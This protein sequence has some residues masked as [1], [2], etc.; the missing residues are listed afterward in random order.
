MNWL[1]HLFFSHF[2]LQV[3]HPSI[4]PE[5]LQ[6]FY[7]SV[8]LKCVAVCIL[9]HQLLS[10][11]NM[12]MRVIQVNVGTVNSFYCYTVYSRVWAYASFIYSS[13]K[14]CRCELTP[15]WVPWCIFVYVPDSINVGV[16]SNVIWQANLASRDL[17][18]PVHACHFILSVLS[19]EVQ[20]FSYQWCSIY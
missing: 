15:P 20:R 19:L 10:P 11:S 1:F 17:F 18:S 7:L 6:V 12:W 4:H 9:L 2:S 16:E 5:V 8:I 13:V 14:Y 3:Y